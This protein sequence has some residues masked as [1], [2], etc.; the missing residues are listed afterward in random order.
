MFLLKAM[1]PDILKIKDFLDE[2][3]LRFNQPGFIDADPVSIPHL[4]TRQQDIEIS[5]FLAA[6]LAWG[7]RKSIIADARR[8]I[9]LMDDAPYDFLVNASPAD[10]KP[11]QKFVHRTFNGDDALFFITSLQNL[12]RRFPGLEPLFQDMN[13]HGAAH[14]ISRFRSLFLETTHLHRSEKHLANPAKGSSAK[15]INMFL[16]WMVRDD[17]RGVDFGLWKT[18]APS[19]LICPLDLHTGQA[20][21]ALGLLRRK[22]NDWKAATE[23]TG[24]LRRLD[25]EDPV[26]Y[27]FALFGLSAFHEIPKAGV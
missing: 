22:A 15:R 6:T 5:G 17:G 21:R 27:D 9:G 3:Y 11:F 8:L 14:A 10:L 23:L 13:Q 12:Y 7:N 1:K 4:F 25:P 18:I 20:A 26:K 2:Q 16:R 19:S 24:F